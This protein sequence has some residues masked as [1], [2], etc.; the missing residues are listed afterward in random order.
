MSASILRA[1]A[2]GSCTVFRTPVVARPAVAMAARTAFVPKAS[3]SAS[4]RLRS[5][6]QEETFEE[7]SARYARPHAVEETA[8]WAQSEEQNRLAGLSHWGCSA[9]VRTAPGA[10]SGHPRFAACL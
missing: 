5:E 2:R 7:F 1:A 6:H 10:A 9:H 4:A 8:N 3:F